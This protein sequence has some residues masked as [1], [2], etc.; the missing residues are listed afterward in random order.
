MIEVLETAGDKIF[1]I[2]FFRQY[3]KSELADKLKKIENFE[4]FIEKK[5]LSIFSSKVMQG[6]LMSVIGVLI[7]SEPDLGK[8]SVKDVRYKKNENLRVIDYRTIK[9]II[10]DGLKYVLQNDLSEKI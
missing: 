3:K 8:A 5:N 9:S 6:E 1:S 2:E 10:I 7:K 4:S